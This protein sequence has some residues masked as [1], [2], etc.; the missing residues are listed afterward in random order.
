MS[1]QKITLAGGCFWCIE[2]ALNELRGVINA[3]SGYSNGHT[4]NPTYEEV[5]NGNT[6]HTEVVQVTYDENSISTKELLEI[7]F[8][9]HDPTQLNRQG[10]DVGTQYR[11]GI[12]FHNDQ[13]AETAAG[14]VAEL[15]RSKVFDKPIVTEIAPVN[16]YHPAEPYHQGYAARNPQNGYCAFVVNPKLAKFKQTFAERLKD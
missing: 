8:T 3:E 13:Q 6:G 14:F 16:N 12:Y 7:F 1:I 10:N 11:C 15:E 5:C 2:A 9:L 4:E